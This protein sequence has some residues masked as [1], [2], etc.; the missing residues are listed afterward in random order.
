MRYAKTILLLLL[1]LTAGCDDRQLD[2][3]LATAD[4]LVTV[5]ADSALHY[6]EAHARLKP[7]GSRSQ[8]MR[9]ELLRAT[10]QN[11]AYVDFTSDS[12]MKEVVA[13]YDD[14]GTANE[15]LQAHYLLGCVYRDLGD[16][17][18]AIECFLDAVEKAD[19]TAED[20]DYKIMS[21]T[22]S[23]MADMYHRQ[24]LLN[25]EIE[26]RKQA[27]HYSFVA[28][29]TLIS[30]YDYKMIAGSYILQSKNDSAEIILKETMVQFRK[31]GKEQE[32]IQTSTMLMHIYTEQPEHMSELKSL[33]EEYDAKSDLFDEN[34]ELP[35][36]K[37]QY[38]Y[39]KGRC[40][41]HLNQLDSAEL[42]YRKIYRPNMSHMSANP[43]YKG[44]LSVYQKKNKSD[45][46]AKYAE[47]YC[48]SNDS[49]S[50]IKD[51]ELTAKMSAS[52]NYS[53]YQKQSI[54]D[55]QIANDRLHIIIIWMGIAI[56]AILA[57]LLLGRR[58]VSK[59]QTLKRLEVDYAKAQDDYTR[60]LQSMKHLEAKHREVIAAAKKDHIESHETIAMLNRQYEEERER[61][62]H[63]LNTSKDK[64]EM[65]ERRFKVSQYVSSMPFFNLGIVKRI[66]IYAGQS[67]NQLSDNDIHTLADAVKEHFP[68]LI[69]DLNATPAITP[70]ARNVCLLT[71]LN[72]KP[73]DIVHLLD[74][75]SPQ[76]SNLRKDLNIAL[77][78]ED[79]SRTLYKNLTR[80]YKILA[81]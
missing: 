76:V 29:D 60:M 43:M 20:C 58:Y 19:T 79:T 48:I 46:I 42:Y 78:N 32:A 25:N 7:E 9:Y 35:P 16:A 69:S 67:K 63:E 38:Y 50:I 54:V 56:V 75:S 13:Y 44:L 5:S 8:R 80:R 59:K 30:I 45:S 23:Q 72:L 22:Y 27:S 77:F 65:L 36:S 11:K 68:D 34:H 47:L 39:Y 28:G 6:L 3:V 31:R 55:A 61:L 33:L 66:K 70:L 21:S 64:V 1:L 74:L 53:R 12:V 41:E 52:Y 2:N 73:A 14:H 49:S 40:Y 81:L 71:I 37:R 10:A 4:S 26:A 17:P 51:Q 62:T 15:Q 24:L 18:R 57:A